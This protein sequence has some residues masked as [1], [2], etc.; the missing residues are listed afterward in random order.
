MTYTPR[1][2]PKAAIDY[3]AAHGPQFS[4]PLCEAIG[5]DLK[6]LNQLM[7][8]AVRNGALSKER[9]QHMGY[10]CNFWSLG[11]GVA[12]ERPKDEPLQ[13]D[14]VMFNSSAVTLP[15]IGQGA[16]L[17]DHTAIDDPEPNS[18][19]RVATAAESVLRKRAPVA[20][21]AAPELPDSPTCTESQTEPANEAPCE[22]AITSV[23]RLLID[24]GAQQIALTK[25][26]A[27]QLMA[28]LDAQR[29]IE[30]EGA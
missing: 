5:C 10:A 8:A 30:W 28:Y 29:G 24:T 15:A 11:D 23:G 16:P 2:F 20:Q 19:P 7:D 17:E 26:Q 12:A 25:A 4:G 14:G 1:G 18:R 21:P 9:K 22:F 13:T 27:D 6:Q 3:I